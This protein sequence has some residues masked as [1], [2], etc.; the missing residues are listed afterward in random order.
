MNKILLFLFGIFFIG[1]ASA[2]IC[3][4]ETANVSTACGGLD[5]GNYS[6]SADWGTNSHPNT[7]DGNWSTYGEV[8][9]TSRTAIEYI[10]NYSKPVNVLNTSKFQTR[11]QNPQAIWN[12]NYS[13]CSSG[14]DTADCSCILTSCWNYSAEISLRITGYLTKSSDPYDYP[15]NVFGGDVSTY[16]WDGSWKRIHYINAKNYNANISRIYEEAMFWDL[17]VTGPII[18]LPYYANNSQKRNTSS[19]SFDVYLTD[20]NTNLSNSFCFIEANGTNQ[21]FAIV[22]N[23]CN[24]TINLSGL[25]DGSHVINVWANDTFGNIAL[26]NDYFVETLSDKPA[27]T[28]NSPVGQ[29]S[30]TNVKFNFT[31]QSSGTLQYCSYNVTTQP[32]VVVVPENSINCSNLLEY[33][34]IGDTGGVSYILNVFANDTLGNF[35]TFNTLFSVEISSSGG[36]GGGTPIIEPDELTF[37]REQSICASFK[38]TFGEALV[39]AR[40]Q[41]KIMDKLK[42][43]WISLWDYLLCSSTAS[44]YPI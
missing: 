29:Q 18:T 38:L 21:T 41:D 13:V 34:S 40:T 5:T 27:I 30:S 9:T 39:V 37:D 23:W 1:L 42:T 31:I 25:V 19:L 2:T 7:Y 17:D 3:Y 12:A 35:N 44:I 4:Q 36:G 16:C 43:I 8:N 14:C 33:Q 6:F 15:N 10:V 20:L 24:A 32:G 11:V 26:N 22:N 28:I